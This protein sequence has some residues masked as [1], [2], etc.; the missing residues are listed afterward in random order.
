MAAA[1]AVLK[2]QLQIRFKLYLQDMKREVNEL[3]PAMACHR[4]TA[5]LYWR[6]NHVPV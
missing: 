3:K 2:E 1:G 6:S 5:L 4:P